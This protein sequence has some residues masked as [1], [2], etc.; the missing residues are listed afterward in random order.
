MLYERPSYAPPGVMILYPPVPGVQRPSQGVVVPAPAITLDRGQ[1]MWQKPSPAWQQRTLS[2]TP[3]VGFGGRDHMPLP[4]QDVDHLWV[5]G[6]QA[7]AALAP[8]QRKVMAL[9]WAEGYKAGAA[10]GSQL[11]GSKH[12]LECKDVGADSFDAVCN[13]RVRSVFRSITPKRSNETDLAHLVATSPSKSTSV[14]KSKISGVSRSTSPNSRREEGKEPPRASSTTRSTSVEKRQAQAKAYGPSSWKEN[15][16]AV[17]SPIKPKKHASISILLPSPSSDCLPETQQIPKVRSALLE[18]EK[19]F[20]DM[21]CELK[22]Q[23]ARLKRDRAQLESER[24]Q[25]ERERLRAE[26][27]RQKSTAHAPSPVPIANTS[28]GATCIQGDQRSDYVLLNVSGKLIIEVHRATLCVFPGTRLACLNED[29][30]ASNSD[31]L[32]RIVIDYDPDIFVQLITLLRQCRFEKAKALQAAKEASHQNWRMPLPI[33]DDSSQRTAFLK[34]LH[35]FGLTPYVRGGFVCSS[36]YSGHVMERG[37]SNSWT[38]SPSESKALQGSLEAVCVPSSHRSTTGS[39]TRSLSPQCQQTLRPNFG[40]KAGRE[41]QNASKAMRPSAWALSKVPQL[42][43]LPKSDT[44][45]RD[46]L[47]SR[48]TERV[49]RSPQSRVQK[50]IRTGDAYLLSKFDGHRDS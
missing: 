35:D 48:K 23:E 42:S 46:G 29:E 26:T 9:L 27:N 19:D 32:G 8:E 1:G 17:P 5:A 31:D 15:K 44:P 16:R 21:R 25:L 33:F 39:I 41:G 34:A 49:S 10:F 14:E 20:R 30:A 40:E 43:R 50:P 18:K 38:A 28:L 11:G 12:C 6:Y 47:P 7:G 13:D 45:A 4:E 36:A 24:A 3:L 22:A 2:H 37:R